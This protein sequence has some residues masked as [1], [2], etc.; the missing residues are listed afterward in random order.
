MHRIFA[1]IS[2]L[3][4]AILPLNA[5]TLD[6]PSAWKR[7]CQNAPSLALNSLDYE[8]F[9][10]EECQASLYPN[11]ELS[12]AVDNVMGSRFYQA[13]ESGEVSVAITQPII[14]PGKIPARTSAA[15]AATAMAEWNY[16]ISRLRLK[17]QLEQAFATA[18]VLQEKLQTAHQLCLTIKA[19]HDAL[20]HM[21]QNGKATLMQQRRAALALRRVELALHNAEQAFSEQKHIIAALWGSAAPDF[22]RV[23]FPLDAV[24]PPPSLDALLPYISSSPDMNRAEAA[25]C[26]AAKVLEAEKLERYPDIFLTA[27][28]NVFKDCD[29]HAFFF[30]IDIPLPIFDRNQGNIHKAKSELCK[31]QFSSI[32]S[33]NEQASALKIAVDRCKRAYEKISKIQDGL[34]KEAGEAHA[35]AAESHQQGMLSILD[36]LEAQQIMHECREEYLDAILDYHH[37]RAAIARITGTPAYQFQ[38][39]KEPS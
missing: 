39:A 22:E 8:G 3:G 30:E 18:A 35:F 25:V 34:L 7:V 11:P 33:Y 29:D 26:A 31:A 38:F 21:R 15:S 17:E 5:Q 4:L 10:G 37:S 9:I 28:Y 2:L 12:V 13:C 20:A 14:T 24:S 1:T 6:L 32:Y 27:G 16:Y 36:V 23:E 19:S